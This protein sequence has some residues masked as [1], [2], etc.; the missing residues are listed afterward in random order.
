M[1]QRLSDPIKGFKLIA[2]KAISKDTLIYTKSQIESDESKGWIRLR[3]SDL[4]QIKNLVDVEIFNKFCYNITYLSV[5]GPI[6]NKYV[7]HD[8]NFI[9]HS[10]SPTVGLT[11]SG[12]WVALSNIKKGEELTIDY[13]TLIFSAEHQF[14]CS[15]KSTNCRGKVNPEDWRRLCLESGH[16][17][18]SFMSKKIQEV[19]DGR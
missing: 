15:C 6:S 19:I 5:I 7:I 12:S 10:C 16:I 18:P 1:I 3:Y 11:P 17:F 9:N 14:N 4:D 13:G 8:S 2:T